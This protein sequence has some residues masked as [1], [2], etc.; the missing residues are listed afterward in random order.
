MKKTRVIASFLLIIFSAFLFCS[1]SAPQKDNKRFKIVT[2][3]YPM[4]VLTKNITEGADVDVINMTKPETGCLHN[5]QLLP[6][7]I[8][9]LEEADVF[10]INGGGMETFM[11]KAYENV[12]GLNVISASDGIELLRLEEDGDDHGEEFNSHVWTYVPYAIKEVENITDGLAGANPENAGIYKKNAEKYINALNDVHNKFLAV[13]EKA[14]GKNIVLTHESFDYMAFGYGMCVSGKIIEGENEQPSA[15][16]ISKLAEIIKAE[17]VI[18]LF[19]EPQYP[20]GTI[21]ILSKETSV[22]V[23]ELD[24]MVT[25]DNNYLG[26]YENVMTQNMLTI[27][28]ALALSEK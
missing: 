22:P 25:G 10:I 13:S 1:C 23:Y 9:E 4:Y 27:E 15:G 11:E 6:D 28:K 8:K 21:K 12:K 17:D 18:G 7:D 20:D 26:V 16:E 24:P 19:K 3:F 5:Y 2:S 14:K